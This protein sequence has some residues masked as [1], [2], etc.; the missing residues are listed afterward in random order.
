M[1]IGKENVARS[2]MGD[3]FRRTAA[4][5]TGDD[6]LL[7]PARL[8]RHETEIFHEGGKKDGPATSVV[9]EE[10]FIIDPTQKLHSAGNPELGG[11]STQVLLLL[12]RSGN[13]DTQGLRLDV[14]HGFEQ[15]TNA[16]EWMEAGNGEDVIVVGLGPV[17]PF[18]RG[19]IEHFAR[20]LSPPHQSLLHSLR[21]CDVPCDVRGNMETTQAT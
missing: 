4:V 11:Q 14:F 21:W 2:P 19:R 17:R 20:Y 7:A 16:L 12:T 6:R 18:R 15:Q 3:Q 9:L 10:R 8:H 1:R 5:D 13:H